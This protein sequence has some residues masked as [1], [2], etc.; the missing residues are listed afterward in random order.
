MTDSVGQPAE[1]GIADELAHEENGG[2]DTHLP[3]GA[4]A[5][6]IKIFQD[7]MARN[8]KL[9]SQVS[10][11]S[12]AR[13]ERSRHIEASVEEFRQAIGTVLRNVNDNASAMRNVAKTIIRVTSDAKA[14]SE[15]AAA[16]PEPA[17]ISWRPSRHPACPMPKPITASA[18]PTP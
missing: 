4:L 7:A 8:R 15:V 16:P 1:D 17:K 14:P 13:E 3:I 9:N 6:A 12:Q 5:R 18:L 11:D 2:E 10:A